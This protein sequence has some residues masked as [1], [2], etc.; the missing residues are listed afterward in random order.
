MYPADMG[1]LAGPMGGVGPLTLGATTVLFDGV[2]DYPEPNRLWK[3]IDSHR[4]THWGLA[5]TTARMLAAAGERWVEPFALD[6]LRIM[7]SAGEP[8]TMPAW[9][10]I[11]RHVGRGRVPI[12]NFSGGPR[13]PG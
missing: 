11:H 9:R 4:V 10:W 12:I 8:W 3:L 1:W 6:S 2:M 13:S 7:G 5:P